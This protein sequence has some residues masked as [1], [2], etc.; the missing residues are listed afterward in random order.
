MPW[1]RDKTYLENSLYTVV[2]TLLGGQWLP[3]GYHRHL[4]FQK[5]SFHEVGKKDDST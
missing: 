3:E 1:Q 5:N 2:P 4:A